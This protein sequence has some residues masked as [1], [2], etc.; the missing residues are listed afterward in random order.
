MRA[1]EDRD[2]APLF[3]AGTSDPAER[4]EVA[5]RHGFIAKAARRG[6]VA[7]DERNGTPCYVQWLFG[8][9]DNAFIKG[10]KGFPALEAHQAL[11]ENASYAPSAIAA[12]ELC[13]W[14]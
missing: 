10:L 8:A 14:R 9:A 12:S 3:D 1:L 2:L 4:R 6:Y 11:L 7:F 13:P 5:W